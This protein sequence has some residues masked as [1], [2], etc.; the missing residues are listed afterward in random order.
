[1]KIFVA[2]LYV[3]ILAIPL[4]CRSQNVSE[5]PLAS[6]EKGSE[7]V[8]KEVAHDEF[9]E[10]INI[11]AQGYSRQTADAAIKLTKR[12]RSK[13][14]EYKVKKSSSNMKGI[15]YDL[16][17]MYSWMIAIQTYKKTT[18]PSAKLIV[19]K[20]WNTSLHDDPDVVR[21][22]I[23]ALDEKWDVSFI[24]D[25]F[26]AFYQKTTD[27]TLICEFNRVYKHYGDV[28]DNKLLVDKIQFIKGYF[29]DTKMCEILVHST[30]S[31]LRDINSRD[32]HG[33]LILPDG[34]IISSDTSSTK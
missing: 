21:W 2:V 13:W 18:E 7:N 5:S 14:L 28:S 8:L 26:I 31:A 19:L 15:V 24:T 10:Y 33:D 16:A 30:E 6:F 32:P 9:I 12:T 23:D 34:S 25:Q 27:P 20:E 11:S 1:M 17:Q 4:S 3:L 29:G 22:Q